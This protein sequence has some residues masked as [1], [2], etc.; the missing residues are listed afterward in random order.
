MYLI[1][2]DQE[3]Q[4]VLWYHCK[5]GSAINTLVDCLFIYMLDD[6]QLLSPWKWYHSDY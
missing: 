4:R 5:C 6:V 3:L 1:H 2:S